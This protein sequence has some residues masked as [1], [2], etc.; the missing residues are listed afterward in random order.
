MNERRGPRNDRGPRALSSIAGRPR[1]SAARVS[2]PKSPGDERGVDAASAATLAPCPIRPSARPLLRPPRR[3]RG[4]IRRAPATA[5]NATRWV[6]WR[7]PTT[8]TTAFRRRAPSATSRSAAGD[9]TSRSSGP[10]STSRRRLRERTTRPAV[11]RTTSSRP[12]C[13]PPTRSSASSP[14]PRRRRR[15][16]SRPASSTPSGSTPSRPAPA[17][18]TT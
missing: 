6:R 8:P 2:R 18:A 12:S 4:L 3:L 5:S 16:R 9:R 10:A 14:M 13:R 1:R 11:S 15:G 7:C 17:S